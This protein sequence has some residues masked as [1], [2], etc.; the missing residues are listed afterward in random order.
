M[1]KRRYIP[2]CLLGGLLLITVG[3]LVPVLYVVFS[4]GIVVH[5]TI[6]LANPELGPEGWIKHTDAILEPMILWITQ[7]LFLLLTCWVLACLWAV[8]ELTRK[9]RR[10][11]QAEC[12]VPVK[13][14]PSASS[15]VR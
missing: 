14:A 5:D 1:K 6:Y 12:T 9:Q 2:W 15:T 10:V 13:A 4:M 3:I 7:P 8:I 11:E